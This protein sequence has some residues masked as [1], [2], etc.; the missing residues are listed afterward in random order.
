[1]W[2]EWGGVVSPLG[3]QGSRRELGG[4]ERPGKSVSAGPSRPLS[5]LP[6]APLHP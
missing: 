6:R 2:G 5:P 4:R 1:M 3:A